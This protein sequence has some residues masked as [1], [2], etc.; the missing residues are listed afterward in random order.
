M[1]ALSA[2]DQARTDLAAALRQSHRMG[3]SEGIVNHFSFSAPGLP[4]HFLIN[5]EGIHWS[6]VRAADI[7]LI[8]EQG[9]VIAGAH[10]VEPTA[11]YIH[12]RIHR[13]RSDAQCIL[14]THSNYATALTLLENCPLEPVSQS[15]LR[16]NDRVAYDSHYN[17]LALDAGEGDRIVAALGNN[18]ILFLANHGVIVCGRHISWAFDDLYYLERACKQQLLAQSTRKAFLKVAPDVAIRTAHELNSARER[19]LS[20]LHFS[21]LKRELSRIDPDWSS[22]DQ[23]TRL[24]T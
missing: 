12:G 9:S 18:D 1:L 5:P 23:P 16:F 2:I 22:L 20:D 3:F 15:A 7:L 13:A 10:H 11:F 14:H 19:A 24:F 4:G 21:A 17:G 8:D 6:E